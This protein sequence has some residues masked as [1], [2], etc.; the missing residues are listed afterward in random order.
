M[1][2]MD[3]HGM[4]R[5]IV[6]IGRGVSTLDEIIDAVARE[7][8]AS[9]RWIPNPKR[10]IT[11][12]SDHFE[13]PSKESL[14]SIPTKD[15]I[16]SASLRDGVWRPAQVHT[17]ENYHKPSDTI[18]P[19]WELSGAVQ[20]CQLYFLVGYRIANDLDARMETWGGV[21]SDS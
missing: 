13:L 11:I 20:D 18:K 14:L 2:G 19:D 15:L 17:A 3:V 6:Q 21:Q 5:D 8:A 4:T 10:A 12:R 1:D 7:Q 16:L 9:S